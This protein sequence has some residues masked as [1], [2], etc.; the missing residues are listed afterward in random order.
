MIKKF[1]PDEASGYVGYHHFTPF[2]L[3]IKLR[4][5][6]T[7]VDPH[8]ALWKCDEQIAIESR[9]ASVVPIDQ[10]DAKLRVASGFTMRACGLR[11]QATT[12][13]MRSFQIEPNPTSRVL[14]RC[15]GVENRSRSCPVGLPRYPPW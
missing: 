3:D 10:R 9:I 15:S 6:A 7:V 2:L 12:E 8:A 1:R 13:S 14:V 11:E 4:L 5:P